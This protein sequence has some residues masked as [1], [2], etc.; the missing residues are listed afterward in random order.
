MRTNSRSFIQ[1]F[2]EVGAEARTPE[3]KQEVVTTGDKLKKD[4]CE[5]NFYFW[6]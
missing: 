4:N 5:V 6:L 1:L 3:V 2:T